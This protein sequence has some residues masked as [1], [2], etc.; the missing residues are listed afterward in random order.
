MTY[1]DM[2]Y[3][4]RHM[5]SHVIRISLIFLLLALLACK[6]DSGKGA[7]NMFLIPAPNGIQ[8]NIISL[9]AT[10]SMRRWMKGKGLNKEPITSPVKTA[11]ELVALISREKRDSHLDFLAYIDDL[12]RKPRRIAS[13]DD[14]LVIKY[15]L[16]LERSIFLASVLRDLGMP[17]SMFVMEHKHGDVHIN[18]H[19]FVVSSTGGIRLILDPSENIVATSFS[20]YKQRFNERNKDLSHADKILFYEL[21]PYDD[22]YAKYLT[23][24]KTEQELDKIFGN[25]RKELN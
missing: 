22:K 1:D 14:F 5:N 24:L 7:V 6:Q 17:V 16:C 13:P 4:D 15:P 12:R 11:S 2:Y 3:T 8:P 10:T 9:E 19:M 20:R 23:S 21:P 25:I 18:V